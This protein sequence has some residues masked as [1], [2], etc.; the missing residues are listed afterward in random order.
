MVRYI[1]FTLIA[2][3]ISCPGFAA[4]KK[5]YICTGNFSSCYHAKADCIGLNS[6]GGEIIAV[7][8]GAI[9]EKKPCK[10][11]FKS[12]PRVKKSG[13]I[14]SRKS[15]RPKRSKINPS[16]QVSPEGHSRDYMD[17]K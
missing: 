3:F 15:H 12:K 2:F 7:D 6:C 13:K 4:R 10:I 14:K 11:C 17:E 9:A 5:F 1:I 8:A 16:R